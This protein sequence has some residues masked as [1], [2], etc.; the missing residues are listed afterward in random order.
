MT[1]YQF[2]SLSDFLHDNRGGNTSAVDLSENEYLCSLL[3]C[4]YD[5]P[6]NNHMTTP[7]ITLVLGA[8]TLDRLPF[9]PSFEDFRGNPE[10]PNSGLAG[11]L[12]DKLKDLSLAEAVQT[13]N[14]TWNL[15]LD[16]SSF[17][18]PDAA[19]KEPR[20]RQEPYEPLVLRLI[21]A[22]ATLNTAYFFTKSALLLPVSI[23]EDQPVGVQDNSLQ[24]TAIESDYWKRASKAMDDLVTNLNQAINNPAEYWEHLHSST[25]EPMPHLDAKVFDE[26]QWPEVKSL[27]T[28]I[29]D[30]L[31]NTSDNQ[32]RPAISSREC[33]IITQIAWFY[34]VESLRPSREHTSYPDWDEL[35]VAVGTAHSDRPEHE[36]NDNASLFEYDEAIAAIKDLLNPVTK[37][38]N[39]RL[40]AYK[41]DVAE[42][43]RLQKEKLTK[44]TSG[45]DEALQSVMT[46]IT[47]IKKTIAQRSE[48]DAAFDTY[49]DLLC[50]QSDVASYAREISAKLNNENPATGAARTKKIKVT[51]A[52]AVAEA[53]D[54]TAPK[55]NPQNEPKLGQQSTTGYLQAPPP[56]LFVTT[57]DIQTELSF[58]YHNPPRPFLVILP[59]NLVI[60][61]PVIQGSAVWLGYV[62]DPRLAR[63]T[64]ADNEEIALRAIQQP[65][66]NSIFLLNDDDWH[67]ILPPDLTPRHCLQGGCEP[68]ESPADSDEDK[69]ELD[70]CYNTMYE[71]GNCMPIIV[72]LCGSP[73]VELPQ[74][75]TSP[76]DCSSTKEIKAAWDEW[77][78]FN[79]QTY[80]AWDLASNV[81]GFGGYITKMRKIL[82]ESPKL[83]EDPIPKESPKPDE[84]PIPKFR[85][86]IILD[87]HQAIEASLREVSGINVNDTSGKS[88]AI[89]T[90]D[91]PSAEAPK[92]PLQQLPRDFTVGNE[93]YWRYWMM[94]GV[95]AFSVALRYRTISQLIRSWLTTATTVPDKNASI[96]TKPGGRRILKR[97]G[98]A[99]NRQPL[100]K[101][102]RD[103][104]E[105][106]E[107][108]TVTADCRDFTTHLADYVIHL[109]SAIDAQPYYR[110]TD[111]R[112]APVDTST[113]QSTGC[114][115][116]KIKR[117]Q[118]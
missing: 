66:S 71:N 50:A 113:W 38:R 89:T 16:R 110:P 53:R 94:L 60:N 40:W 19:D 37:L 36:A 48:S 52:E 61:K 21:H 78:K 87:E 13:A 116:P 102:V 62:V 20:E 49:A 11:Q 59:V 92:Q 81:Q 85:H 117:G 69:I 44:F 73:L 68:P 104:L 6:D 112:E 95:P 24:L 26:T 72:K 82:K 28:S 79:Q 14:F 51:E 41:E 56:V 45:D 106:D 65:A 107:C 5:D 103:L 105:I 115:I 8:E 34:L 118:K 31:A 75:P 3:R 64:V 83:D 47:E 76:F 46:A 77:K 27:C 42:L 17:R 4:L 30:K 98:V 108:D 12:H 97:L 91:N 29:Q 111:K 55:E 9:P 74:L 67:N 109:R 39:Q 10:E 101:S 80:R 32:P 7:W 23:N 2:A 54:L 35:L 70:V 84:Y 114:S 25:S 18:T 63:G 22:C 57:L 33:R 96:L 88:T 1:K 100:G 43:A 58:W 90:L 15:L 86:R 93:Y 99:V